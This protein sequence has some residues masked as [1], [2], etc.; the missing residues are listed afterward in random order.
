MSENKIGDIEIGSRVFLREGDNVREYEVIAFKI[1][2]WGN[3]MRGEV[4]TRIVKHKGELGIVQ[5]FFYD[6]FLQ[7]LAD[8][9][10][11]KI[12]AIKRD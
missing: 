4:T 9:Q 1:L 6:N 2:D 3:E 8:A 7:K 5:K 11:M 12:S 10:T